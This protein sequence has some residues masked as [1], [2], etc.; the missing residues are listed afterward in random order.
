MAHQ[1]QKIPETEAQKRD[2]IRH[3]EQQRYAARTAEEL[4]Q[5]FGVEEE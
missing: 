5:R 2:R 3:E 1:P 4:R